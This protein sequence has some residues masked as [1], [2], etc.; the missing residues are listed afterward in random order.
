MYNLSALILWMSGPLRGWA[1]WGTYVRLISWNFRVLCGAWSS[2]H[3]L[4]TCRLLEPERNQLTME[5]G[6]RLSCWSAEFPPYLCNSFEQAPRRSWY[7]CSSQKDRNAYEK[8][9]IKFEMITGTF[10]ERAARAMTDKHMH[11]CIRHETRPQNHRRNGKISRTDR[12]V[13]HIILR[14]W[15]S[16]PTSLSKPLGEQWV[17]AHFFYW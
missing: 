3:L 8:Y 9:L 7:K 12:G 1:R 16:M 13:L 11:S 5:G 17:H 4:K 14:H 2:G 6:S 15:S 10:T